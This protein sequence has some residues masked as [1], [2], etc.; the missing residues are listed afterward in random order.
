M[1]LGNVEGAAARGD[2]V[3]QHNL[4]VIYWCGIGVKSDFAEAGVW[5]RKAAEQGYEHS[6]FNLAEMYLHGYGV[7]R[8]AATA[9]Y[10]LRRGLIKGRPRHSQN[11][12]IC[13]RPE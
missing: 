12:A 6:Q 5:Y 4:G 1:S 11:W 10:W 3:A 2:R 9:V 8:D 13:T 7:G